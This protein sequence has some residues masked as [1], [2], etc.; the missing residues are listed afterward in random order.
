MAE[1]FRYHSLSEDSTTLTDNTGDEKES[2][3]SLLYPSI[4]KHITKYK[5]IVT[6]KS[7]RHY[8]P[9]LL[10]ALL[11]TTWTLIILGQTGKTHNPLLNQNVP[12]P[13]ND[14]SAYSRVVMNNSLWD[15]NQF[16]G[17][18]NPAQTAAW[19]TY[20]NLTEIAVGI[21]DLN[22]IG[23]SSVKLTDGPN[24]YLAMLDV[25][26]QLHC[27]DKIRIYI[28]RD[29]YDL[30][31]APAMQLIHVGHCLD[32]LRQIIMCH[33]DTELLTFEYVSEKRYPNPRPNPNFLVERKC[34]N[35]DD[36]VAWVTDHHADLNLVE[37]RQAWEERLGVHV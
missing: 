30:R 20:H 31:E 36:I 3:E 15:E 2:K 14:V 24:R 16:K 28:H 10:F 6:A 19:L 9:H 17:A 8:L 22:A 21:E 29:Y 18:P 25:F 32:S 12:S 33:A 5:D 27:L 35:W 13:A 23:K 4:Q 7:L 26:H 34:K 1:S 37:S 11:N